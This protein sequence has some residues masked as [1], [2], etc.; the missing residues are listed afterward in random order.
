MKKY[1]QPSVEIT[2]FDFE[3]ITMSA[4][5]GGGSLK[6]KDQNTLTNYYSDVQNDGAGTV[7]VEW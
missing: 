6:D 2:A 3:D 4:V 5:G 1:T 7:T